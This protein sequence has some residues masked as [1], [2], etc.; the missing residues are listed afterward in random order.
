LFSDSRYSIA[1]ALFNQSALLS[2]MTTPRDLQVQ[3]D[4]FGVRNV[5]EL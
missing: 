3:C 4:N 1:G 5:D 2:L